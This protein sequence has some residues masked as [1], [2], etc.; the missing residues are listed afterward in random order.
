MM[1]SG[2]DW[3]LAG[4]LLASG[5]SALSLAASESQQQCLIRYIQMLEKWNKAYNLTSI[6]DWRGMVVRHL[7]DSVSVSP[8]IKGPAVLDVGTGA[9]MPGIPLAVLNPDIHFVLLDTN[10]KKTRFMTQVK[11]ELG[12]GNIAVVKARI[13]QYHPEQHF[14]QVI[15]RAY[16]SLEKFVQQVHHIG[17]QNPSLELLAMK[18][19]LPDTEIA[20]LTGKA[21]VAGIENLQVPF[22]DEQRHL[23]RLQILY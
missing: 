4:E 21:T 1:N 17:E 23:I 10:G 12:I 5:L 13:E 7:L 15:C 9:G 18:G 16:S 3:F 19:Q 20:A 22:L 8:W 2:R 6:T 11:A 14:D